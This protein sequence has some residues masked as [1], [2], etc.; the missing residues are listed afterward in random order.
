MVADEPPIVRRV[1]KDA[2]EGD[3]DEHRTEPVDDERRGGAVLREDVLTDQRGGEW[4]DPDGDQEHEV[5]VEKAPVHALAVLEQSVV[6]HPD[7]ADREK[8]HEVGGVCR[9]QT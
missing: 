5:Q 3:R 6:V 8:A 1:E 2:G 4:D 9:P 7:D